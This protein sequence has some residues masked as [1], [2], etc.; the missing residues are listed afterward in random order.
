VEQIA[1]SLSELSQKILNEP[2]SYMRVALDILLLISLMVILCRW[3]ARFKLSEL[4][5]LIAILL[6]VMWLHGKL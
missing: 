3:F 1:L 5:A 4:A 6:L 2:F